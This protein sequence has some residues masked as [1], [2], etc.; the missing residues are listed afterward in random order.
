MDDLTGWHHDHTRTALHEALAIKP[1]Q[2]R[3]P[4]PQVNGDELLPTL[5]QY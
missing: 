5:V 4:R 2:P 3:Q 1:T